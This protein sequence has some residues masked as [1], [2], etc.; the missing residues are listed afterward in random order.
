[1]RMGMGISEF[2]PWNVIITPKHRLF[3]LGLRDVWLSRDLIRLFIRRNFVVNYRQTVLGPLWYIMQP[4][5]ATAIYT[6]IFSVVVRLPTD[7]VPPI[8]FYLAGVI[9]WSNFQTNFLLT[10]DV[11]FS[12]SGLFGK[13]YFPRL[14]VPIATIL[15]NL[16][17]IAIHF[18]VFCVIFLV[19]AID[20][21]ATTPSMWIVLTPLLFMANTLLALGCGLIV[22]A[23][24]TRY[25][26]LV[27][28]VGSVIPLLMYA[29]PVLYPLSQIPPKWWPLVA[30]NPLSTSM[31][32][33]RFAWF[34]AGSMTLIQIVISFSV[35]CVVLT[36][37]LV[38]FSRA[39]RDAADTV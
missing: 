23:V 18:A 2:T 5:I 12:N 27:P 8:L 26:D 11:F 13:V 31:E 6:V 36:A 3:D 24:T 25:R 1:M 28:I 14:T 35:V 37:G 20:G 17:T 15:T 9:L 30:L 34:G 7:N 29:T 4:L 16:I 22:S 39:E 19:A 38:L 21:Q 10:S 32:L 33:F